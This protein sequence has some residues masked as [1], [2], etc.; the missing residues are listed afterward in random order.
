MPLSMSSPLDLGQVGDVRSQI[1]WLRL[2]KPERAK[3][4]VLNAYL[5]LFVPEISVIKSYA[6]IRSGF[7]GCKPN[8]Y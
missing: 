3:L 1:V 7:G 8:T 2:E 5:L 4:T 6:T